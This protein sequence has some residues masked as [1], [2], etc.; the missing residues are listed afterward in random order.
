LQKE[1]TGRCFN[2]LGGLSEHKL[3]CSV[4]GAP[5]LKNAIENYYT[6]ASKLERSQMEIKRFINYIN[7]FERSHLK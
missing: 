3:H 4:L 7:I 2:A 5:A 6:R 1:N